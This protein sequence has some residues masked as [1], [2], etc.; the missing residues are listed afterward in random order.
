MYEKIILVI[1]ILIC[2]SLSACATS[3][4]NP[5]TGE[6]RQSVPIYSDCKKEE[7][8]VARD[9]SCWQKCMDHYYKSTGSGNAF[10]CDPQCEILTG[11]K[12]LVDDYTC[13]SQRARAEGWLP[14]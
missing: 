14:E 10:K 1:S 5:K 2:L 6:V 12:L 11:K 8:E 9:N 7:P 4:R 3:W 13:N